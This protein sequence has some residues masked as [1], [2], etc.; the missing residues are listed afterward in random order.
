VNDVNKNSKIYVSGHRGLVGSA[1]MRKLQADGYINAVTRTHAELDLTRQAD[2]DYFFAQEKPEYVFHLAANVGGL[3]KMLDIPADML[4]ENATIGI[5]ILNAAHKYRVAKLIGVS[6]CWVYSTEMP[7]PLKPEYI[8]ACKLPRSNEP[9]GLAKILQTKLCEYYHEQF[10]DKF[11]SV[12]P[13]SVYGSPNMG[14]RQFVPATIKK[15][16]EAADSVTVWGD[17]TP[18][19]EFIHVD[20]LADALVF[21]MEKYDSATPL[22]IGTG[23]EISI[24]QVVELVRQISGFQGEV[25]Y[26]TSKPK[27]VQRLFMDCAPLFE[28]GWKPKI[29]LAEGLRME[30]ERYKNKLNS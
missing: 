1:L 4:Y 27:G 19:R 11:I 25:V 6:S 21:V 14:D 7:M 22:N 17:G 9:Y 18:T 28:L 15:F 23:Q 12:L 3:Q 30:Y 26:D 29:A 13:C 8:G 5:N 10:G 24:A 16:A 2:V 20:D